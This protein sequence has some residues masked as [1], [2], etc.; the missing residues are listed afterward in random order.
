ME[1]GSSF[2][3]SEGKLFPKE[4]EITEALLNFCVPEKIIL[5]GSRAKGTHTERFDDLFVECENLALKKQLIEQPEYTQW[6]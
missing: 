4:K 6:I 5:F 3:S 1:K 2:Q